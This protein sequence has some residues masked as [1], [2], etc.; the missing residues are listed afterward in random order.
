MNVDHATLD[1]EHAADAISSADSL[2][3]PAFCTHAP[4]CWR[5]SRWSPVVCCGDDFDVIEF[6]LGDERYGLESAWV[7]EVCPLRELTPLPCT[8]AFVLGILNVRGQIRTVIDIRRFFDLPIKGLTELNKVIFLETEG[9]EVG[10]LADSI[11]G[12][13]SVARASLQLSLPT[14]TGIRAEY[15]RGMTSDRL[16][17]LDAAR[18][19][20]DEKLIVDEEVERDLGLN[21]GTGV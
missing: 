9:M 8:P 5:A 6:L 17:V 12:V 1:L 21:C 3:M 16:A 14:L 10:I 11:V 18:I 13:R 19:L 2:A 15:L 4:I 20:A 7:R